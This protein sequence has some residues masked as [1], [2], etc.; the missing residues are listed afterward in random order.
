MKQQQPVNEFEAAQH[1]GAGLSLSVEIKAYGFL[2]EHH[3]KSTEVQYY[4][5]E[6]EK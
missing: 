4:S 6:V 2:Y 1:R 5:A 3:L